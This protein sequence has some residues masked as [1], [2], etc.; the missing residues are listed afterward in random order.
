MSEFYTHV[1]VRGNTILYTGYKN[2]K[3]VREKVKFS[4]TLYVP[5]GPDQIKTTPWRT[6]DNLPVVPFEFDSI[7]DCREMVEEYK[8]VQGYQVYGNTDYQYQF[9]GDRFPNLE[10]DPN[11]LKVCYLDIETQCEDGFPTV[12]KADQKVNIIT[13]RFLQQGQ[14]T[15]HT[16]CLGRAK[17]VQNN[18]MVFEYD[19][20]KE[21]LQAFIEQWKYYDFDI[22]TGWNIQFFDIPYLVNRITN[23]FGDG[24]VGRLSPWGI[25]KPRK[26]YIMQREQIAYDLL[27]VSILDYLDLYKKFT[28]VTQESYSLNHISYAELG[29]KKTSFEGFDGILDMYTRDFQKFVQYN[30]KDVDLVVKL[31][32]KLKLLELAL[33][34]AY[35]A[36]VN[37][38]DVF[39][40]VRTWDTIIYHYLNNKKIV[41]PQKNIEE[42]DTA[43]VGAYVKEPQ[44]GMHKWIVSFDLDSLYPHLIMQYNISPEMKHEMGKRGTLRPEDV[45]YP[46][47]EESKKQFLQLTDHQN[48]I[49][50]KNLSMAAN[51]VYFKKDKQGFLAELMETMYKERKMYK[52]KMLDSK[53][54]LK[55]EKNLSKEEEQQIKFDISKYHNFQLVRKIQ[56]NSA[57]GAVGN[58]YFRYYDLDLAEAITVSGQ[59]SIRWIE[60][61]L[62]TF[63]NK[64]IG[65]TG[66]DYVIASDTDSVYLCLDKLVEK[67][68]KGNVPDNEKVVKFLD[69]ACNEIINPFIE[70]KYNELAEIM[71]AYEQKMHMKRESISSKG[72]WTAKKRYML[73]V[74][75][76][77]DNVLL[78]EPEMKIMGIETTRSSTP[79][80]VRDG[81]KKAIHIIMNSDE[82]ALIS[83]KDEFKNQFIASPVE[84]V[85]FPRGCN[86]INEY[87]DSS[88]IYKKSTPIAVKGALLFN[89]HIKK[90]KLTKKYSVIKDG[91]KVKFVYLKTPNP[92]GEHVISFTNTLP[93]ELELHNYIDYTKQFE[94]SFIEPLSTIVKVIGWDL[95][96]R[97]TLE[98]LFI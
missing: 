33:A 35:S 85:S 84:A 50:E 1:S 40:Q 58:Q 90:H 8:D 96:R 71:N 13:V 89:H 67:S 77:E 28:F 82:D 4:P 97:T 24:E 22:I 12:E 53:R 63:L 59:L 74:M 43:F 45:L 11:T 60:N 83:F 25:V 91:E 49:R 19:S 54:R 10:Y 68:F 92:I 30:V 6:L 81:L 42:K 65:T 31:E 44:V 86:G 73:N 41:I 55:N 2:G 14:E 75:M 47:S 15:I 64:N 52:E 38:V 29:E 23:L 18:H 57:F 9:I 34:L 62:N 51:G 36:K 93:K 72:I 66:V 87:S 61:A 56:L 98:S 94:K 88:S 21:M 69:K 27:G 70:K 3:R 48:T 46:N 80:I 17:P 26:V 37:L 76:G 5:A 95:E 79:Q 16:Y 20:E 32:Q 78:K 39:S 7:S